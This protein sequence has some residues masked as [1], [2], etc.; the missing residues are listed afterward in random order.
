VHIL[1][2]L[3]YTNAD[4]VQ[5]V[6]RVTLGIVFFA[7]GAQKMFGWFKGPGLNNSIKTMHEHIHIPAALGLLAIAAEFF[8]GVGLI[9]GLLSRIAAAGI[10]VI[11]LVAIVLVHGRHGL[12]LN[13][14]G[15]REGHGYE[16]HLLALALAIAVIIRGSGALSLD[17][18]LF[19]AIFS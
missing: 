18:F 9:V 7:H 11:M 2:Y 10:V 14:F 12:F 17:H 16:Y 5:F 15:D 6:V 1:T 8:G 13:W 19:T 4:W 3:L